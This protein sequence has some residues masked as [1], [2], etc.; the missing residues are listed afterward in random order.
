VKVVVFF[1]DGRPT[2]F[3]GTIGGRQRILAV[4]GGVENLV[5]GYFDDPDSIEMDRW[6]WP[7]DDACRDVVN[8]KVWTEGGHPPH[9]VR[10][11]AIA[12]NMGLAAANRIRDE[13]AYLYTIGLGNPLYSSE[14]ERPDLGYLSRLANEHGRVNSDQPRGRMYFAPAAEDLREVFRQVAADLVIR[15]SN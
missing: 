9:G 14:L 3:R 15:L 4:A 2:A 7:P 12:R 13:G 11:R 10:G 5:R 1:T 8:C 6:I